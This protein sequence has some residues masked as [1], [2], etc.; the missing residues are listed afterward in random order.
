M[1]AWILIPAGILAIVYTD[2]IVDFIGDIDFA[3]R[4]FGGGGTYT[5]V[6]L[7]GLFITVMSFA[8]I[9]GGIQPVL[10]STFGVFF[11]G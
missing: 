11:G 9:M 4:A 7:F 5:F 1:I 8:W 6:K 3:E 10:R 2:K